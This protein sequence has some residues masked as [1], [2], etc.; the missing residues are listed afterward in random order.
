[1]KFD[2]EPPRE[3]TRLC[4][5]TNRLV[6]RVC[7]CVCAR[8]ETGCC[9][10]TAEAPVTNQRENM[11]YSKRATLASSRHH[12]KMRMEQCF[13]AIVNY[14]SEEQF[15]RSHVLFA[16]SIVFAS[17][18]AFTHSKAPAHQPSS[19]T[20]R[21]L[22][23]FE[24]QFRFLRFDLDSNF[25]PSIRDFPMLSSCSLA[26]R[27]LVGSSSSICLDEFGASEMQEIFAA[28]SRRQHHRG[29]YAGSTELINYDL[30]RIRFSVCSM[31]SLSLLSLRSLTSERSPRGNRNR[32]SKERGT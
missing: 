12:H 9:Q 3:R 14:D 31:F 17:F 18:M 21:S 29:T 15:Y 16:S 6:E 28:R 5:R 26:R 20:V 7:V 8:V 22:I 27:T 1:M 13:S 10:R 30:H 32:A 2:E 24:F 19:H 4:I 23:R 25:I 11:Y